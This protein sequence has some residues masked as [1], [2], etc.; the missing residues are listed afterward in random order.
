MLIQID[1]DDF[2]PLIARDVAQTTAEVFVEDAKALMQDQDAS[3]RVEVSIRDYALPGVLHKPKWKINV[4]AGAV[5]GGLIGVV[6]VFVLRFLESDIVHSAKDLE[7]YTGLAVLG[8]IPA[9]TGG[10]GKRTNNSRARRR[11]Q[12]H[13]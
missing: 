11:E 12:I 9:V 13:V 4:M 1:A 3:D 6:I 2:D 5:F 8:L 10:S 7:E